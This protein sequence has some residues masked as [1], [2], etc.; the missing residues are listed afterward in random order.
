MKACFC[1]ATLLPGTCVLD[2]DEAY[3]CVHA[4][5]LKNKIYCPHGDENL[6]AALCKEI[7]GDAY[8]IRMVGI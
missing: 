7:L 5:D 1:D 6:A 4:K 2:D 8:E 3:N